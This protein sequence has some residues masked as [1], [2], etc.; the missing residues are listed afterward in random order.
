[1]KVR[2]HDPKRPR[3][4]PVMPMRVRTA[5]WGLVTFGLAVL[6]IT[7]WPTPV[8][9]GMHGVLKDVFDV[10]HR[11]RVMPWFGY[12]DLER[13]ANVAMFVPVGFFFALLL[14]GPRRWLALF[15][16]PAA[17]VLIEIS[18]LLLLPQRF[19]TFA[20]V[21]ANSL[22]GWI[23]VGIAALFM[24]VLHARDR[25]RALARRLEV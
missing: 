13:L 8:D 25:E 3:M 19:A 21:V 12:T 2:D 5:M 23:G 11:H 4:D 10:L 15:L 24:Q 17:S 7:M 20:D 16:A 6:L 22:G 1:M 14:S 9:R 18:Q